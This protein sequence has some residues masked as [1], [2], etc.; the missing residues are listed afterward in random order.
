MSGPSALKLLTRG[1]YFVARHNVAPTRPIDALALSPMRL[2]PRVI[3]AG[4]PTVPADPS[5]LPRHLMPE[6]FHP[7]LKMAGIAEVARVV[8]LIGPAIGQRHDMVDHRRQRHAPLAVAA[9]A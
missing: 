5:T 6:L 3:G 1:R 2:V 9:L 7:D 8:V 4:R